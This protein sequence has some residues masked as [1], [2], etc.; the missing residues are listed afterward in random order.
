MSLC[1]FCNKDEKYFFICP[2]CGKR[3]C[4]EHRKTENHQCTGIQIPLENS[5][6]EI[7][8][9][10]LVITDNSFHC[11]WSIFPVVQASA[12]CSQVCWNQSFRHQ[13]INR[14]CSWHIEYCQLSS[15]IFYKLKCFPRNKGVCIWKTLW[16]I[17]S[18][19][20]RRFSCPGIR[21]WR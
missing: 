7:T 21:S 6:S 11:R 17:Q 15:R 20:I 12:Y 2:R 18:N 19:R 10:F 1:D 13:K 14:K 8:S 16:N 5:I 9:S 3:F 4:N